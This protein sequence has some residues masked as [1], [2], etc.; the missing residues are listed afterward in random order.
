MTEV[1]TYDSSSIVN[2]IVENSIDFQL[3]C[4]AYAIINTGTIP[5]LVNGLPY[6]H[7]DR[8]SFQSGGGFVIDYHQRIA[9]EFRQ[10]FLSNDELMELHQAG[11]IKKEVYIYQE[12]YRKK[13]RQ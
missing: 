8:A 13:V 7:R 9:I 4:N 10:D 5:V 11:E 1:Q 12:K 3:D 2:I 6:F